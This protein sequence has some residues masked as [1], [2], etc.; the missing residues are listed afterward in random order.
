M[1]RELKFRVY[2]PDDGQKLMYFEMDNI[3]FA[4]RYLQQHK[5]PVQQFTGL[6]DKNGTEIYEGDIISRPA[7]DLTYTVIYAEKYA[8]FM[9][10]DIDGDEVP[11]SAIVFSEVIGNIYDKKSIQ[12]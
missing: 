9:A 1:N 6:K 2:D 4:D 5:Y 12:D 10:R 7:A 3:W 8:Q 11:L